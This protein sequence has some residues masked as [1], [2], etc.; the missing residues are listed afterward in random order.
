VEDQVAAAG[1]GTA[2]RDVVGRMGALLGL[3]TQAV[4]R[5]EA[6]AD[7]PHAGVLVA[8]PALLANGLL[9]EV[10][11]RLPAPQGFYPQSQ[12]ILLMAFMALVRIR[13]LEQLRY[14]PCGEWGRILG[15]DRIP[16]VKTLRNRLRQLAA[17]DVKSWAEAM[18]QR[19]MKSDPDQA[20]IL[21]VDGHVRAYHGAQTRLP[22]RF[23]SRDR[24][25]VRSLMDY[26]V[27]DSDG[28]P[29]FVVTA[30]GTEGL[31]YHLREDIVPRLLREVPN[32]PTKD[33]LAADPDLHRFIIVFD[34]EGWS[35]E[36]FAELWTNHRIA[37]ITYRKGRYDPW[38]HDR[39]HRLL[40]HLPHGNRV[41]MNLAEEPSCDL[42]TQDVRFREVRRLS[43]NRQHQTSI[44]TTC[45]KLEISTIA[46]RC[47]ARWSQENFLHYATADLAID[48]LAGYVPE[49][50]PDTAEV[51][52]PIWRDQDQQLRRLRALRY[53]LNARI[54]RLAIT[55]DEPADIERF[56]SQ[57][58]ELQTQLTQAQDQIDALNAQQKTTP[59]RVALKALPEAQRPK[60]ISPKRQQLINV[61]KITAYRAETALANILRESLSHPDEA[62]SLAK[63]I[64]TQTADLIPDH[65]AKRLTVRLHHATNPQATRAV[66]RLLDE[67]NTMEVV[68]P[69][70]DTRIR[71]ELVST[72]F[73]G[74]PE[75]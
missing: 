9:A 23:S 58:A 41:E 74:N 40:V 68:Y 63:D 50:A 54:G 4:P 39:F 5:F 65:E 44:I 14:Q 62:R 12:L 1:L 6:A 31:L 15:L 56:V 32:Q 13:S 55:A 52:N 7:V 29:F 36:F 61:L 28:S 25:C 73:P 30:V 47:F 20:G 8:L 70:T 17:G 72:P 45:R 2:C 34:R 16:E 49:P 18:G 11:G 26:W 75:L 21:Y 22:E 42:S 59:R 37:V 69:G 27:N 66:Q 38:P 3:G 53:D 67:L 71:Y 60:L 19:W 51:R 57:S 10:D 24:L 35:P 43:E 64:F 46:V 33:E 48:R